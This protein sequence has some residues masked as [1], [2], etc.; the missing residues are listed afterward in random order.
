[1]NAN[2]T[3]G[4]T[5]RRLDVQD[6]KREMAGKWDVLLSH[7]GLLPSLCNGKEHPCPKCNGNTRFHV[8]KSYQQTGKAFCRHCFPR[9]G[10]GFDV[11][12]WLTGKTQR[13]AFEE[14]ANFLGVS[15][16]KTVQSDAPRDVVAL[17]ARAKKI[18]SRDALAAYGAVPSQEYR[19]QVEV[20][21]YSIVDGELQTRG[22]FRFGCRGKG[23]NQTGITE[24]GIFLPNGKSPQPGETWLVVEGP[25]DAA[26]LHHLGYNAA[27]LPGYKLGSRHVEFFRGVDV[28]IV[29]DLDQ[30]GRKGAEKSGGLIYGVAASVKIARL[31][32]EFRDSK[33]DDVRDVLQR[34]SGEKLIHA[35]IAAATKFEPS[36]IGESDE[37]DQRPALLLSAL[38]EAK[39]TYKVLR[40]LG[41]L[42]WETPWIHPNDVERCKVY[43][44]A[45]VLVDAVRCDARKKRG[46]TISAGTVLIREIPP[47]ILR[48]RIGQAVQLYKTQTT[49]TGGLADLPATPPK[50]LIDALIHRHQYDGLVKVLH[51]VV[52]TPTLRP[53]GTVLQ[54]PGYDS[55]TG[56]LYTPSGQF[57]KVPERCSREE[58]KANAEHIRQVAVTD[59]PFQQDEDFAAWLA[60]LLTLL[61][62]HLIDGT[63]PAFIVTAN[64]RGSGKSLLMDVANVIAL[65]TTA[66]RSSYSADDAEMRKVLTTI[67]MEAVPAVLFDNLATGFGGAA[68]DAYLT[69]ETWKDRILG[70]NKSTGELPI[71]GVIAATGNNVVLVGDASRR[72]LPIRLLSE[73]ERP[74][75]R[76]DFAQRDL[77]GYLSE[78]R[79]G[80]VVRALQIVQAYIQAGRP[81]QPKG[82]WGGFQNWADLI[83]GA[84]VWAT[85][86]DA[87]ATRME[88]LQQD[89]SLEE[90]GVI[91]ESIN[92]AAK[93]AGYSRG[94]TAVELVNL[95]E[96]RFGESPRYPIIHEAVELVC[97]GKPNSQ[98]LGKRLQHYKK[99]MLG[100]RYLIANENKKTKVNTWV[101]RG[102]EAASVPKTQE[103]VVE[104]QDSD[105]YSEAF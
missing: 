64:V 76:N 93:A 72:V 46:L 80:L 48:E 33:G 6:L 53:D 21:Q 39:I 27:G 30:A 13:E 7:H 103:A 44:R 78:V 73:H 41:Q 100:G 83:R 29:P 99:R 14:V 59:F 77:L 70:S 10:D 24:P 5:T 89:S 69:G 42:G 61:C 91:H 8:D 17:V 71:H 105:Y 96:Q 47:A 23:Y 84:V 40:Y 87:M 18:P 68:I 20:P 43:Q 54:T 102:E 38:D 25:K 79:G 60:Y 67:V 36:A 11:L 4:D 50:Q 1:M 19:N 92:E 9:G 55:A 82:E 62:R 16:G 15:F 65:G 56:L 31:P 58:A 98:K 90:L 75:T 88:A 51:G 81:M 104:S 63:T 94:V 74:E 52:T 12:S 57:P 22:R 101:L 35:A 66:A 95:A 34:E 37:D 3:P 2:H 85:G 86:V 32:G 49:P 97:N 26:T 45:G 28:V